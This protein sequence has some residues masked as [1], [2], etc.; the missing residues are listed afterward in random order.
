MTGRRV[1]TGLEIKAER[2]KRSATDGVSALQVHVPSRVI[3]RRPYL[4]VTQRDG[5]GLEQLKVTEITASLMLLLLLL[6]PLEVKSRHTL[7]ICSVS[8]IGDVAQKT[9]VKLSS[10]YLKCMILFHLNPVN[11]Y[12]PVREP[13][14][15]FW[16]L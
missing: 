2:A 3:T 7:G 1:Q 14:L 15:R 16:S 8:H 6:L 12:P 4:H 5:A 9:L 13:L 10:S 11:L